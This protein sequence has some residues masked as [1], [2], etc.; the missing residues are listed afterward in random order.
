LQARKGLRIITPSA[1][2]RSEVQTM[3]PTERQHAEMACY[4]PPRDE[5]RTAR[6]FIWGVLIGL[7]LWALL[8]LLYARPQL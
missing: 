7:A 8:A 4:Q 3:Q 1:F 6:G 2:S 5:L